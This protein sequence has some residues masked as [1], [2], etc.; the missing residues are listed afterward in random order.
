MLY[1]G[2]EF[3]PGDEIYYKN[4][5]ALI[6]LK[7]GVNRQGSYVHWN[8]LLI[9]NNKQKQ[10]AANKGVYILYSYAAVLYSYISSSTLFE[11]YIFS[12]SR[13]M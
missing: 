9:I 11:G 5:M 7:G 10:S 2:N 4:G 3:L 13:Q 1:I 8:N 6:N 12:G